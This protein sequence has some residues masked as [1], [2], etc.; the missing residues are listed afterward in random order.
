ME[1]DPPGVR[2]FTS[3]NSKEIEF[4]FFE[5]KISV[6]KNKE[7]PFSNISNLIFGLT[8]VYFV[9]TTRHGLSMAYIV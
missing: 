3:G 5:F 1:I 7:Y 4:S 2:E 6:A 9:L 8:K